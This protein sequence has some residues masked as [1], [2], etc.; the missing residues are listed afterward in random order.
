VSGKAV[1]GNDDEGEEFLGKEGEVEEPREEVRKEDC[2]GGEEA[3][4][5][6]KVAVVQSLVVTSQKKKKGTFRRVQRNQEEGRSESVG[7]ERK[8]EAMEMEI[9][10]EDVVGKAKVEKRSQ[11]DDVIKNNSMLKAGLSEQLRGAQ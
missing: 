1:G 7:K 8:R 11:D 9:D 6:G 10:G 2:M 4:G 3:K 5:R